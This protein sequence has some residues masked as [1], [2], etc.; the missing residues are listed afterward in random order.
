MSVVITVAGTGNRGVRPSHPGMGTSR[1]ANPASV[2]T[3][4][5]AARNV[6]QM[7]PADRLRKHSAEMLQASA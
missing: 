4:V 7:I 3:G 6:R 2:S 1:S 5:V